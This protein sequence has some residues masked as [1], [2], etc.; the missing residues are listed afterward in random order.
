MNGRLVK[1]TMMVLF[2]L[3]F[4]FIFQGIDRISYAYGVNEAWRFVGTKGQNGLNNSSVLVLD[5]YPQVVSVASYNGK[6]YAAWCEAHSTETS[7]YQVRVMKYSEGDWTFIDGGTLN[8]NTNHIENANGPVLAVYDGKLFAAWSESDRRF[9]NCDQI[10]VKSLD[11]DNEGSSWTSLS[12]SYSQDGNEWYG[13]NHYYHLSAYNPSLTVNNGKLYAAWCETTFGASKVAVKEY[14]KDTGEWVFIDDGPGQMESEFGLNYDFSEST[15]FPNLMS[16]NNELYAV[17]MENKSNKGQLRVKKYSGSGS[18]WSF[19][20]GGGVYGLNRN[21]SNQALR[22]ALMACN[23]SL[24]LAWEEA[25]YNDPIYGS[26]PQI[27]VKKYNGGNS[28][29]FVDGN[30]DWGINFDKANDARNPV[31]TAYN[32]T[33]YVSWD[34]IVDIGEELWPTQ[35]RVAK[36]D[37]AGF[38]FIDGNGQYGLN[39]NTGIYAGNPTLTAGDGK[40]YV[41]WQEGVYQG[42]EKKIHVKMQSLPAYTAEASAASP[43]PTTGAN[44]IITLTVKNADGDTDTTFSGNKEVTV[45]GYTKAPD[46]TYGSFN[47]TTL[48]SSLDPISV[49]FISGV[50]S[51]NLVLHHAEAQTIEFSIAGVNIPKTN[52]VTITPVPATAASMELTQ[53]IAAPLTNGGQFARQPQVTLK[54]AYGNICT[55]DTT[56]VI[57]ASKKDSGSWEL[58]GTETAIASTGVATFNNLGA[59]NTASVTGAKLA[60]DASDLT[61]IT[62][63]S[64]ILPEITPPKSNLMVDI[65]GSGTVKLNGENITSENTYKYSRNETIRLEATEGDGYVFAY[66]QD[67]RIENILSTD[68]VYECVMGTGIHIKAVFNSTSTDEFTVVFK[69]QRGRI[70]KTETVEKG[71]DATPPQDPVLAGYEFVGW[72]KAYTNVTTD[73]I[74]NALFERSSNTYTV[75]VVNG[76]V[77]GT[78]ENFQYDTRV[79]VIADTAPAGQKFSHW[80]QNGVKISTSSTYSFFMPMKPITLE[81]VFVGEATVIEKVPFITLLQDVHVDNSN[82]TMMFFA[83]REVPNGYTLVENGILLLKESASWSGDL[84]VDTSNVLYGKIKN[85]STDQFYIRKVDI[86]S[87]DTWYARAY[88]IYQDTGGNMIT[89]Y[90]NNTENETMN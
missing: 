43:D 44:N 31:L 84:T 27:R 69:D 52:E 57:T 56:T 68:R 14:N 21:A 65:E 71:G 58:T 36:Y 33:L 80:Q 41:A 74:I 60:F 23:G 48:T 19:V 11:L 61:Q 54:D 46:D 81:A 39:H 50:A 89:V 18:S 40:F 16:Y 3:V 26:I 82:K 7:K 79:T 2:C 90:S 70:L 1:T 67:V 88:L 78:Q 35:I 38:T 6:L 63:S 77:E 42:T 5:T 24:Y 87:G 62:S 49:E 53:D 25:T 8:Y 12:P 22:P 4:V 34:E 47:G 64:V 73:L 76:R 45:S 86:N 85:N 20:D 55:N 51:S 17:W 30:N 10:K 66:W 37:G 28:W 59:S 83:N 32:D 13:L 9:S 75:T 15:Y 29:S 72:D